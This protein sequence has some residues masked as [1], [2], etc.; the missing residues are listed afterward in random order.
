MGI[1]SI[2]ELPRRA[3]LELGK[4]SIARRQWVAILDDNTLTGNPLIDFDLAGIAA[5]SFQWGAS[6][7][8]QPWLR[9]RKISYSEHYEGDPYK[10]LIEAE[11]GLIRDEELVFPSARAAQWASQSGS[12]EVPALY[13]YS[14]SGNNTRL[15]LTNSAYDYYQGLTASEAM[16]RFTVVKN[17]GPSANQDQNTYGQ[18]FPYTQAASINHLNNAT[19][20]GAPAH[21]FKVTGVNIAFVQEEFS[22]AVAKYWQVTAELQ[23]RQTGWNLQLP[24][25]GFNF[26]DGVQKRRAMVFDFQNGEWIASPNPVGLNGSGAQTGGAPAILERRVLPEANFTTIFGAMPS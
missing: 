6:H 18:F 22:A 23:Y 12:A 20:G 15:P 14:G 16:V 8:S 2:V 21:T 13:Y 19:Y 3:E 24:D 11:Y 26:I 25:V 17:F 7:P 5:P 9:C 4:A 10:A 1:K